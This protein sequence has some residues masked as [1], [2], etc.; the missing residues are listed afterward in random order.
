MC[1]FSIIHHVFFLQNFQL[2]CLHS[3]TN[4]QAAGNI[5]ESPSSSE[6]CVVMVSWCILWQN[7]LSAWWHQHQWLRVASLHLAL[8]LLQH[9]GLRGGGG[10]WKGQKN[11]AKEKEEF[12]VNTQKVDLTLTHTKFWGIY[13]RSCSKI[14]I[15]RM[16]ATK[17]G[18]QAGCISI[19]EN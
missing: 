15:L 14:K 2:I 18:L 7:K 3:T 8:H 13:W 19:E 4:S 10:H 1:G 16:Y 12:D 11:S 6:H 5:T 17:L 9:S